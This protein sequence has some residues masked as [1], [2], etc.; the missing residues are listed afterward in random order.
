[1][2]T[3]LEMIP[4]DATKAE[5]AVNAAQ[6]KVDAIK[7]R[8]VAGDTKVTAKQLAE[9]RA[10]LELEELR[11]VA[12]AQAEAEHAE[13]ERHATL[14]IL[15]QRLTSEFDKSSLNAL[16]ER[17]TETIERYVSAATAWNNNLSDVRRELTELGTAFIADKAD[18]Y[19]Q[20]GGIRIGNVVIAPQRPQ[21][22]INRAGISALKR[23]LSER[24]YID[25]GNPP[26]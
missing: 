13:A 26:D 12:R 11:A 17:M 10:E 22:G 21:L 1:M 9:A 25:L 16:Y 18:P 23:H 6:A 15:K 24:A 5:A 2:S 14:E 8:L 4:A 20:V 19:H 7:A 3:S